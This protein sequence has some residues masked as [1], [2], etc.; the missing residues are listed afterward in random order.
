MTTVLV[1]GATGTIGSRVI[2]E[3]AIRG[4]PARAFV[5]DPEK[6]AA[7]LGSELELAVG[8]LSDPQSV[9]AALDGIEVV[10][11]ACANHPRQAEFE[12]NAINAS[13]QAGVRRIVKLSAEGAEIGSAPAFWDA[14][15]RIE[16]QL[17]TTSIPVVILRPQFYMSNVLASVATVRAVDTIFA[18]ADTARIPMVHPWDVSAVA[19]VALTG[20]DHDGQTLVLTGPEAITFQQVAEHLS[21]VTGRTVQ[22]TDLPDEQARDAMVRA[23]LPEWNAQN[24]VRVF[25]LRRQGIE[26]VSDVVRDVTGRPPRSFEEFAREHAELFAR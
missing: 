17:R 12:S 22:F 15:G 2:A 3:L 11:L 20:G 21:A 10:F 24:I 18:P 8:D 26:Q 23:G 19:A 6:A 5:R 9:R 14:H 16:H 7:M 13:L 4:V 1:T 25:A